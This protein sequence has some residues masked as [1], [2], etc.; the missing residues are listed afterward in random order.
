MKAFLYYLKENWGKEKKDSI[1]INAYNSKMPTKF[2]KIIFYVKVLSLPTVNNKYGKLPCTALAFGVYVS[3][4]KNI[5]NLKIK[6]RCFF[7]HVKCAVLHWE[8]ERESTFICLTAELFFSDI[9]FLLD[10][11]LLLDVSWGPIVV[12]ILKR[13]SSSVVMHSNQI[14]WRFYKFY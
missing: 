12:Q 11:A 2:L 5:W 13:E 3:L 4:Q 1:T 8:A 14:S 10:S 7:S 9:F 6:P